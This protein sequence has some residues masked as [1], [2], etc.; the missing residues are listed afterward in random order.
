M[1]VGLLKILGLRCSWHW[2]WGFQLLTARLEGRARCQAARSPVLGKAFSMKLNC[3]PDYFRCFFKILSYA[4]LDS[5]VTIFE[6]SSASE[7][8]KQVV[9]QRLFASIESMA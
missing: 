2:I 4:A 1:V 3:Y 9:N 8:F 6:S 5:L 7:F